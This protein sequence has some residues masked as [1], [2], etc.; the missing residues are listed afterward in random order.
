MRSV[1]TSTWLVAAPRTM[2]TTFSSFFSDH[3]SLIINNRDCASGNRLDVHVGVLCRY[4]QH[5]DCYNCDPVM[6]DNRAKQ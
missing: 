6:G 4:Q 3:V 2:I 1:A 5:H